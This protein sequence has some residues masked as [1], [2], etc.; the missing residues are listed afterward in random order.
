MRAVTLSGLE[1]ETA[2]RDRLGE[3]RAE[4]DGAQARVDHPGALRAVVTI[5][6]SADWDRLA[7]DPR[8]GLLR[9]TVARVLCAAA[10]IRQ[11][12]TGRCVS[13]IRTASLTCSRASAGA[14]R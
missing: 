3:I 2:A 7:L 6:A 8:R 11:R 10:S 9:A 14:W 1:D 5:N 12:R 13:R 4:R